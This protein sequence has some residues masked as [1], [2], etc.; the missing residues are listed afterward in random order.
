MEYVLTRSA[1]SPSNPLINT[2]QYL[3]KDSPPCII[4]VIYLEMDVS[5]KSNLNLGYIL[6]EVSDL[7]N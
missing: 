6:I 5:E 1:E 3:R 2:S 7:D 4:L